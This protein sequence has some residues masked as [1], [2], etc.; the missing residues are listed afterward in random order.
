MSYIDSLVNRDIEYYRF[1]ANGYLLEFTVVYSLYDKHE[2]MIKRQFH[3]FQRY[4]DAISHIGWAIDQGCHEV[5]IGCR[6]AKLKRDDI[7]DILWDAYHNR[8]QDYRDDLWSED[9][10]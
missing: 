10:E 3:E 5:S 2:S 8:Q 6:P 4:T 7:W 1:D 9:E